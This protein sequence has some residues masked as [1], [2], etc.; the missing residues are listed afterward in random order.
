MTDLIP[1]LCILDS[2]IYIFCL[3]LIEIKLFSC[4]IK[5]AFFI[6]TPII[7]ALQFTVAIT[8]PSSLF[9]KFHLLIPLID[10]VIIKICLNNSRSV[11]IFSAYILLFSISA[12]LTQTLSTFLSINTDITETISLF[13]QTIICIIVCIPP[14]NRK[15]R[16]ILHWTPT[17]IKIAIIILLVFSVFVISLIAD[18]QN[19]ASNM[20]W[21]VLTHTCLVLLVLSVCAILPV[22]VVNSTTNMFL[23]DLTKNYEAQIQVQAKHYEVI[24]KNNWEIR[25]FQHDSKNFTI[26]LTKLLEQ[27]NQNEA[28]Q[29]LNYYYESS[30]GIKDKLLQFDTGNG[31]V[32]A[33]LADKQ[34]SSSTINAEIHF[35][36]TVPA[37]G[38]SPPDL[39]VLFGSTLDNAID[40]CAKFPIEDT[41]II[42]IVS[43]A[44]DGYLWL[45]INNPV[46]ENVEIRNNSIS[47]TKEDK[48]LHGFGLYS[49]QQVV[50]K[51]SGELKLACENNVF[52]TSIEL[53][54]EI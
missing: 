16:N 2:L 11:R 42:T 26:G 50:K 33:L 28:L 23:K 4:Q 41:K 31:I 32:D 24:A 40:A 45:K 29:M 34:Q 44:M 46:V 8:I 43:K 51:H 6:I 13:I 30:L 1:L 12:I 22:L 19:N 27:G 14:I 20:K 21:L 7:Y 35:E 25:R 17:Y 38:I 18:I 53:N 47:T 54:I 52:E 37:N 3:L 5:R 36:G 48:T 15:T 9:I 10:I 39:C 49:L